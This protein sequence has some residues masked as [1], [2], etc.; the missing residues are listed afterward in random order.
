MR[1]KYCYDKSMEEFDNGLEEKWEYEDAPVESE[2]SIEKLQKLLKKEDTLIFYG[3]EPLM[4]FNK[5]KEIMDN[6]DCKFYIQTNGKLLNLVPAEYLKKFGKMLISIDGTKERNDEQKGQGHYD[7]IMKNID[8]I[9]EKGFTGE[10]V[11]R[12]TVTKPDIDIQVRHLLDSERFNSIHF[13]LDAGFYKNDFDEIKFREFVKEYNNSIS[14]LIDFWVKKMYEGKV[15]MI[16]PF[17]GIFKDI[18]YRTKTRLRC[19]SGYSNFTIT[20]KGDLSACPIMNAV[21]DFYCGSVEKGVTKEIGC[22]EPCGSC[23]YYDLCGGRCLYSNYA[24]LWGSIGEGLIC[25]T[26]KHLIDSL[27]DKEGEIRELVNSKVV[28]EKDLE[29]EKYFGPEIIP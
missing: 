19:G 9:R 23:S 3:G 10:I 27:Q 20:T 29:Y 28:S 12:M 14:S 24:K 16:Y 22:G 18:Y 13:Q 6:L 4:K 8:I 21:K 2:V 26:I 15:T 11:A 7:L 25:G 1:C 17:L 5:I